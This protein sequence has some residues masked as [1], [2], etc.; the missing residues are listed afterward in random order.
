MR[1]RLANVAGWNSIWSLTICRMLELRY[2]GAL[3]DNSATG[4]H[5]LST[6]PLE[7]LEL[8]HFSMDAQH[9]EEPQIL[10]RLSSLKRFKMEYTVRDGLFSEYKPQ[11]LL[12]ALSEGC[13]HIL[14]ALSLR[15]HSNLSL[16]IDLEKPVCSLRQF[17]VLREIEFD[18]SYFYATGTWDS[19]DDEEVH[20]CPPLTTLLS[21][22]LHSLR[23]VTLH[24]ASDGR[25]LKVLRQLLPKHSNLT[26]D[27]PNLEEGI[28]HIYERDSAVDKLEDDEDD[29]VVYDELENEL[30][31]YLKELPDIALEKHPL[32]N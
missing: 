26:S 4:S 18:T 20:T 10:K 22:S 30:E 1:R 12:N 9:L 25:D 29:S 2:G 13:G 23:K 6:V 28:V 17:S 21:Q 27:F 8:D 31:E 15:F 24:V 5:N 32:P 3:L 16:D 7:V 14:E 11:P 19:T